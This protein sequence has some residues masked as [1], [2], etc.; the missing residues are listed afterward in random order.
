MI[1]KLDTKITIFMIVFG[2]FAITGLIYFG[3]GGKI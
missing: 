3:S 2:M 1:M